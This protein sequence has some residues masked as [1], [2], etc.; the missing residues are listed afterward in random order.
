MEPRAGG[1]SQ[2]SFFDQI[3]PRWDEIAVHPAARVRRVLGFSRLSPGETVLD[4]GCGTGVLIPYLRELGAL[5]ICALDF[6]AGMIKRAG[7]KHGGA[8][9]DYVL[10]DFLLFSPI[11]AFDLAIAY[12]SYPHFTDRQA[13]FAKAHDLLRPGGRL[14][15][16]H[17]ESRDAINALHDS[18]DELHAPAEGHDFL[19]LPPVGDTIQEAR[20]AGFA[21]LDSSEADGYYLAL[22]GKG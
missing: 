3:A 19:P 4:I 11:E 17:I 22:L 7:E 6:A 10:G 21:R 8:G 2:E 9:I 13:F 12:S 18:V 1:G 5:R 20:R 15:I 16:A 14:C